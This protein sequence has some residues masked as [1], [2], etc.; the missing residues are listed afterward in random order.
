MKRTIII[1]FLVFLSF[2]GFSQVFVNGKNINAMN[3]V[4]Y[5]E[6]TGVTLKGK[7]FIDYG[8]MKNG[9]LKFNPSERITDSYGKTIRFNSTMHVI[10]YMVSNGWELAFYEVDT[11]NT[12]YI[13]FKK[14]ENEIGVNNN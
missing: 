3:D 14:V 7:A 10:N 6:L 5:C 4:H 2:A 12:E 8:Q 9:F 13:M 1:M 11:S